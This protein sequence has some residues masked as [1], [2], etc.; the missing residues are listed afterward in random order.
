[1]T[2]SSRSP[3]VLF[4]V[5][6]PKLGSLDTVQKFIDEMPEVSFWYRCLPNSFFLTTTLTAN[7]FDQ[8]FE[9]GLWK[10]ETDASY[11]ITQVQQTS[12]NG[13]LPSQAWYMMA[14]PDNPRE[15]SKSA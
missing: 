3:R 10:K 5:F 4:V 1:M 6:S 13:R 8:R 2:P 11:F 7:E 15:P 14:H 12:C 9:K